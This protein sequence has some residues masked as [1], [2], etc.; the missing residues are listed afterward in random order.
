MFKIQGLGLKREKSNVLPECPQCF[1]DFKGQ[2][3]KVK[4]K[5]ESS[6]S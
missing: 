4:R 5:L 2:K 1:C 3:K 6:T